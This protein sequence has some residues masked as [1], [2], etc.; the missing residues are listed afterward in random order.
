[1]LKSQLIACG[2]EQDVAALIARRVIERIV[3]S[4]LAGRPP[5]SA[6][7]TRSLDEAA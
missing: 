1:M 5:D 6:P 2:F 7:A 4:Y 3:H